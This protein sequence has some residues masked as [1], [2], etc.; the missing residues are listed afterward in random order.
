MSRNI[1]KLVRL[2]NGQNDRIN[3][4]IEL[5]VVIVRLLLTENGLDFHVNVKSR[6]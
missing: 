2:M 4:G 1:F 6:D 3:I 5:V